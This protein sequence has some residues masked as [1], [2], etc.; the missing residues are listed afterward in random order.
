MVLSG[1]NHYEDIIPY[2]LERERDLPEDQQTVF[3]FHPQTIDVGNRSIAGYARAGRKK[4]DEAVARGHTR[5]D[6]DLW[7]QLIVKVER[8][9]FHGE[10]EITEVIEDEKRLM[11]ICRE[12]GVADYNEIMGATRDTTLLDGAGKKGL[13]SSSGSPSSGATPTESDSTAPDV[14]SGS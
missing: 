12:L 10:E 8:F 9:R 2:V 5:V 14:S 13:S 4:T 1:I 6:Y 3:W 11:I 7:R